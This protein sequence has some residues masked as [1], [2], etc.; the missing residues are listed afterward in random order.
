MFHGMQTKWSQEI[1]KLDSDLRNG[2]NDGETY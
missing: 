1:R 2:M